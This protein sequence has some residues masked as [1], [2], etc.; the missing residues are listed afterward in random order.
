MTAFQKGLRRPFIVRFGL[1]LGLASVLAAFALWFLYLDEGSVVA[2]SLA[3]LGLGLMATVV[4][5]TYIQR[6]GTKTALDSPSDGASE[7]RSGTGESS[8]IS[9]DHQNLMNGRRWSL[10]V[11]AAIDAQR[12]AAVCETWFSWAGFDTRIDAHRT[13]EG[14]DIWLHAAKTPAP[15]AIVRC[16]HWLNRPVEIQEMTEFFKVVSSCRSA[17]G[18]YT[19]TSTYTPEALQF[20]QEHGIDAVDGRGLLRRIQTRTRQRQQAL[21]AVAFNHAAS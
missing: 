5:L 4:R 13:P 15:V 14:V 3:V 6:R 12:F 18:T 10:D 2:T 7:G 19:T 9:T 11:F 21:L 17:H 1:G 20:A 8:P 16:K